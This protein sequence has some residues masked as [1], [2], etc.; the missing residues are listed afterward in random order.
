M[1]TS[2]REEET[3]HMINVGGN[4]PHVRMISDPFKELARTLMHYLPEGFAREAAIERLLD[5]KIQAEFSRDPTPRRDLE[6]VLLSADLM[7]ARGNKAI[8]EAKALS[9]KRP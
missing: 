4:Q 3:L 5:A 9:E 6:K 1:T 2:E 7:L 8:R